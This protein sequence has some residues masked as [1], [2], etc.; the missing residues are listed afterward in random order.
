M[1]NSEKLDW[2]KLNPAPEEAGEVFQ[3]LLAAMHQGKE[4]KFAVNKKAID[5]AR[6][7]FKRRR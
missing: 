2:L 4:P 7:F 5:E 6:E 3:D 1:G